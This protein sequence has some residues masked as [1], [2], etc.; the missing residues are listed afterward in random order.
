[1][2]LGSYSIPRISYGASQASITPVTI[3]KSL[4]T[5]VKIDIDPRVQAVRTQEKEQIKSL[6][7]RFVSF[8]DK[9]I[10]NFTKTVAE[11]LVY[12]LNNFDYPDNLV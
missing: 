10:P 8:I 3:N 2:S 4:L 6:N 11:C 7:N 5:P 1:M 9:V 12:V